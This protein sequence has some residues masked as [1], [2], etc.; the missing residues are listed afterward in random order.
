MSLTGHSISEQ[1]N[2][3]HNETLQDSR[4]FVSDKTEWAFNAT[5]WTFNF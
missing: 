1:F 5:H 4:S 2:N 3:L